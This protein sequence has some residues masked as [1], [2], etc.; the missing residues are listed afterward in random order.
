VDQ[1][2]IPILLGLGVFALLAIAYTSYRSRQRR[3]Q[4]LAAFAGAHA[5]DF[6]QDDPFGIVEWDFALFHRGDGQGVEHV[7]HGTWG[8]TPVRAFDFWYYERSSNGKGGSSK[9]YYR[10]TC[11]VTPIEAACPRLI[12]D[13]EHLL[14]RLADA[15]TFEDIRFESEAF[16]R[17][18]QVR[19]DDPAF[20]H[21]FIDAR[22]IA[23][24]L[25]QGEGQAYEILGDKLMVV[26]RTIDP[27][28]LA[29][30]LDTVTGFAAAVPRVVF[31]LYPRTG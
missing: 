5:L 26:R 13:E 24:M 17:A 9:T 4:A 11:A 10:F 25:A 30:L 22:M 8:G 12:V 1:D 19:S 16:N 23:W 18:F 6:S 14:S 2:L 31:S 27:S 29:G 7:L 20:A 15:L 21:A 28:E 3:I